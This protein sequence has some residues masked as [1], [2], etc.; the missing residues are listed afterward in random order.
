MHR[1]KFDQTIQAQT[2][3]KDG[4]HREDAHQAQHGIHKLVV[5]RN[6]LIEETLLVEVVWEITIPE[7]FHRFHGLLQVGAA[8]F[9]GA[10]VM[11]VFKRKN[12]NRLDFCAKGTIVPVFQYAIYRRSYPPNVHGFADDFFRVF[13]PQPFHY[14]FIDQISLNGVTSWDVFAC[15]KGQSKSFQVV[16]VSV[17]VVHLPNLVLL[18]GIKTHIAGIV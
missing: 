6:A 3:N 18:A 17:F 5:A 2:A 1:H 7:F 10:V 14:F 15:D 13:K 4:D 12:R 16:F 9:D 8:E 11:D